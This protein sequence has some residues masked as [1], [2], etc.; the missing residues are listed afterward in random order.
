MTCLVQPQALHRACSCA[1]TCSDQPDL[2]LAHPHIPCNQGLSVQLQHLGDLHW[3]TSQALLGRP[4]GW[5]A[6]CGEPAAKRGLGRCTADWRSLAGK[7][8][9]KNPM[10][11]LLQLWRVIN[12]NFNIIFDF[13]KNTSYVNTILSLYP[14]FSSNVI[15]TYLSDKYCE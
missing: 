1:S 12:I 5:D 6:S 11:F 4:S 13:D 3:S 8:A 10:S 14:F 15:P 2:T 7:V 9:K